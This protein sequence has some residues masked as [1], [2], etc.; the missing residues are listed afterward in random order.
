VTI[1]VKDNGPG[2]PGKAREHLFEAFTGSARRGGTGLGLSIARELAR[3]HG[4]DLL[5]APNDGPG[6]IFHVIIPDRIIDLDEARK[7]S[8]RRTG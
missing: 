7:H 3:A 6:T 4:G 8:G 5:L 1:A 2:L